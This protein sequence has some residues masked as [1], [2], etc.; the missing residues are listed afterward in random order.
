MAGEEFAPLRHI[1]AR[2][3]ESRAGVPIFLRT[4]KRMAGRYSEIVVTFKP[5]PHSIFEGLGPDG[6]IEPN[7]L[8][9]RLQQDEDMQLFTMSKIPGSGRLRLRR[10]ALDLR[11]GEAFHEP[12]PEAYERLI[13]DVLR[14]DETLFMRRDEVEAAW[15]FVDP[16]A[17]GWQEHYRLAHRYPAGANGPPQAFGLIA[18][19]GRNWHDL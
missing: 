7:R 12:A 19:E 9:I 8:I 16:I 1:G 18:R 5:V 10:T 4:G 3:G 13:T 14:G 11:F 17:A 2:G 15:S 6:R